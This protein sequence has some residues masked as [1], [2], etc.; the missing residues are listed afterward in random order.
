VE[1]LI[2]PGRSVIGFPLFI[3]GMVAQLLQEPAAFLAKLG[4]GLVYGEALFH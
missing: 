1:Q 4:C 2:R 3:A